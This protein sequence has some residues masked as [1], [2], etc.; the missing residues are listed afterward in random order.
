L[1]T[2]AAQ[3][4][5]GVHADIGSDH[6]LLLR[7]LLESNSI[8]K[9][10]A[11]ENKTHPFRNSVATL[12]ELNVD[13]RLADGLEGLSVGEADSL[14][15]CGMGGVSIVH[16]LEA[17]PERIPPLVVLQPNRRV[18]L[19]RHWAF[20]NGF[21]LV[22][23]SEC[24]GKWNYSVLRFQRSGGDDPAYAGLD[25]NAAMLFGP[26]GVRHRRPEF[27]ANLR[28]QYAHLTALPAN[29]E[30]AAQ[31]LAAISYLLA[32]GEDVTK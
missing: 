10:I 5:G 28:E 7:A 32:Q 12:G 26:H 15:I 21:H 6:G 18:D 14:S 31:K 29:D 16:I 23:E 22:D 17:H 2:V 11:I 19:A 8:E 1:E 27:L 25:Q 9:G 20:A 30:L 24:Y 3:I 13:V 4:R